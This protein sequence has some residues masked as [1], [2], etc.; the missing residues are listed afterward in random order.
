[1]TASEE[2]HQISELVARL[3]DKFPHLPARVVEEEVRG[4]HREFEDH[5][6]R[7]FI[8]LLVE[9][10]AE[11]NLSRRVSYRASHP[12]PGDELRRPKQLFHSADV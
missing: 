6:V 2:E 4:I 3:A 5:R 9:R 11:R 1:M 12:T 10:I 8:P 7:E